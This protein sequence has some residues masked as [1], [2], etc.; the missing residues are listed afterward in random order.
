M[1]ECTKEMKQLLFLLF[2]IVLV[3]IVASS[4][5]GEQEEGNTLFLKVENSSVILPDDSTALS[6]E[7]VK[8]RFYVLKQEDKYATTLWIEL[9]D[10]CF[11]ATQ[12]RLE[13]RSVSEYSWLGK[14][15]GDPISNVVL[16]ISDKIMFGRIEYFGSVYKVE[17][18]ED[19]AFHCITK[20]DTTKVMPFGNDALIPQ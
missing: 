10:Q 15:I 2:S 18:V 16:T 11:E 7:I 6:Q 9:F 5:S 20:V 4:C 3:L 17:P 1:R 19:G 12:I 13:E 14:A 8:V